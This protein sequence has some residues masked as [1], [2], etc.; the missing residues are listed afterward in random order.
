M[1]SLAD[2]WRSNARYNTNRIAAVDGDRQAT[3]GEAFDRAQRLANAIHKRGLK[4]HDRVGMLAMNRLEWVE[5]LGAT[6]LGGTIAALINYRLAGPEIAWIVNDCTPR[7][8]IFEDQYT[9]LVDGLRAEMKSIEH[10]VCIGDA[11]PDWAE[12]YEDFVASG[13]PE[14]SSVEPDGET[15]SMLMYT[16]GTTGR[17]KGVLKMQKQ[18]YANFETNVIVMNMRGDDRLLV[19]M[20]L[21]HNGA[22]SLFYTMFLAGGTTYIHRKFDPLDVLGAFHND[23]ITMA[24]MAPTL[25][26]SI[27]DHPEIDRYDMSSAR[28]INYAAAPMPISLLRR[29]V[30]KFGKIFL[31]SYGATE[32]GGTVLYPHQ[33]FLDGTPEQMARLPSLGQPFPNAQ[34]RIVDD[35]DVDCPPGVAGEILLKSPN[36]MSGYWNNHA[37]TLEVLRDGWYHTGD[38]GHLDKDGFLFL[39]DRKKDMIISGGENI[40]CREV[41]E[42]LMEH[43]SLVDVAV[44]GVPDPYWGENVKAVAIRKPEATVTEAEL[45]DF[46][47]TRI[48]RYKKPKSVDFVDEL[49]RLPSGKVRKNI[50]RDQYREAAKA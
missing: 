47:A 29:C 19:M 23:R 9:E 12:S 2:I 15:Y 41:E 42:A 18:F 45:I 6:A 44:I 50:L 31:N 21:F 3:F 36:T 28:V 5:Y 26:Q 38:V 22:C 10:Y 8:L 14:G 13:S 43:G 20:P 49:P 35:N 1:E 27:M 17:P 37:A 32:S 16:S 33:H 11:T 30:A 4:K 25:L 7:I 40:Y 39:V 48:A 34:V 24:H 46:C